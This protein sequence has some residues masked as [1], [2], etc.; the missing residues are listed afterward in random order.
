MQLSGMAIS[1]RTVSHL[2]RWSLVIVLGWLGVMRFSV[3]GAAALAQVL[4]QHAMLERLVTEGVAIGA[5]RV[6]GGVQLIAA[7]LLALGIRYTRAGVIGAALA[8]WLTAIPITLLLTNPVWIESL[9]GFPAIGSG[10]GI[11]KYPALSGVA[12][13]LY[14]RDA[15]RA[16]LLQPALSIMVAGVMLPLLWIGGMKFTAVE[17]AGI[18]PLLSTSPLLSWMPDVFGTRTASNVIGIGELITVGLLA[19]W[20]YYRPLYPIGTLLASATFLTTL[21]FLIT[22]PGWHES[23]GFPLLGGAGMFIIK[24]LG[25][26]CAV[27][28]PLAHRNNNTEP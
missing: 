14:A 27:V 11:I 24:D 5:A 1:P 12:L 21:S 25:L 2:G 4:T 19:S 15:G 9:G 20:W 18:E 13:L 16:S 10:Q 7:L 22:L 3:D 17:A 28:I 26:W 23:L 6:L 8:F